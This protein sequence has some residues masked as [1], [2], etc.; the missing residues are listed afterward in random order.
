MFVK[1]CMIDLYLKLEKYETFKMQFSLLRYT[2]TINKIKVSESQVT[3]VQNFLIFKN[4]LRFD[5]LLT[6]LDTT[7]NIFYIS[8]TF[9]NLFGTLFKKEKA[10]PK[11]YKNRKLSKKLRL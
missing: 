6:L 8:A 3:K 4:V 11:L 5:L 9:P 7:S 1:L 2:I 10:L